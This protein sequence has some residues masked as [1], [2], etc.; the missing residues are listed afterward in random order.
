MDLP[1]PPCVALG[2]LPQQLAQPHVAEAIFGRHVLALCPFATTWATH[3]EDN[4]GGLENVWGPREEVGR[5]FGACRG[6]HAPM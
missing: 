3:H 2:L 6:Q 4:L 5:G 1:A